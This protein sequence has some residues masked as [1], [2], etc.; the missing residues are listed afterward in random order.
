MLFES[1]NSAEKS[2]FQFLG[3]EIKVIQYEGL[4]FE[5]LVCDGCQK[6]LKANESVLRQ[7]TDFVNLLKGLE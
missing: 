3:K 5:L 7:L 1:D 2:K 6:V 4:P